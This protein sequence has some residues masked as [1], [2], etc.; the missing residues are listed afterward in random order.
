MR[1]LF[2]VV[3]IPIFYHEYVAPGKFTLEIYSII[4]AKIVKLFGKRRKLLTKLFYLLF[5]FMVKL[6]LLNY[7]DKKKSYI[8]N[9]FF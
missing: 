7:V 3:I 5:Q 9:F 2:F 4:L 8:D 1:L 6:V